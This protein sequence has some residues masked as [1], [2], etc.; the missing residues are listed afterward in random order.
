MANWFSIKSAAKK[1]GVTEKEINEWI[2]LRYVTGSSLHDPYCEEPTAEDGLFVDIDELESRL[3][4][5]AIHTLPDDEKTVRVPI[6]EFEGYV[7]ANEDLQDFNDE[8]LELIYFYKHKEEKLNKD[9]KKLAALTT[10]LRYLSMAM[11]CESE[12]TMY[13]RSKYLW[14]VLRHFFNKSWNLYRKAVK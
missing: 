10:K 5:N 8:I 14:A 3:R 1:Y 7:D 4:M 2:R 11:T 6:Q 13:K 9:I 12:R